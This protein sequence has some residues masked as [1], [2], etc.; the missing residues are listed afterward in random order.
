MKGILVPQND[1]K[2]CYRMRNL[3]KI[4]LYLQKSF[5]NQQTTVT[6]VSKS[7]AIHLNAIVK[8]LL[9]DDVVG[10]E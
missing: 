7:I 5:K 2:T 3:I 6:T 10:V 9:P 4:L 8:H 1:T